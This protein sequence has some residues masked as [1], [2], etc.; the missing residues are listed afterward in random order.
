MRYPVADLMALMPGT[1]DE[2]R[3][4]LRISAKS[5]AAMK[6]WGFTFEQAERYAERAGFPAMV[7]WPEI[8][9]ELVERETKECAAAQCTERFDPSDPRRRYCSPRCR[10]NAARAAWARRRYQSDPEFR[11]RRKVAGR[12][13]KRE[14]R[15]RARARRERTA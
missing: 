7:V 4:T 8:V 10:E 3:E 12:E 6:R 11:E 15:A 14:V 1:W 13:Y 5:F 2:S 9:D